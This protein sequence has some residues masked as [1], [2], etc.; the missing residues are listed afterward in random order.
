[1]SG[2]RSLVFALLYLGWAAHTPSPAMEL[3]CC[4]QVQH[5]TDGLL[6]RRKCVLIRADGAHVAW[7]LQKRTT[8]FGECSPLGR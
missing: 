3:C 4:P 6:A 7:E 1:M 5:G 8:G 2:I